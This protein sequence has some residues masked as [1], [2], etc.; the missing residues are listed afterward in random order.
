MAQR[1]GGGAWD[2]LSPCYLFTFAF[3]WSQAQELQVT[4]WR[5]GD[6]LKVIKMQ[7]IELN[8]AIQRLQ[9]EIANLKNQVGHLVV[10]FVGV[11][12]ML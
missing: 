12:V 4:A 1:S 7:V 10:I 11:V 2:W 9:A 6:D 8:R 5:K 3:S